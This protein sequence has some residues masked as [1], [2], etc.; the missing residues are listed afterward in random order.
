MN[1]RVPK[2]QAGCAYLLIRCSEHLADWEQDKGARETFSKKF[3]GAIPE[4][5]VSAEEV[6]GHRWVGPIPRGGDHE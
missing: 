6:P 5:C 2:L 1:K 3:G 4:E